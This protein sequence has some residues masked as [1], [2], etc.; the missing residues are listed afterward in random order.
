MNVNMDTKSIRKNI[1]KSQHCQRNWLL[2]RSIPGSDLETLKIAVTECP[3]KQN[4]A[5]Y[6]VHFVL[7]RPLIEKIHSA[8]DGFVYSFSPKKVTTNSQILA[9]LVV[10]FEKLPISIVAKQDQW[11]NEETLKTRS[12][13]D[14][15]AITLESDQ[16]IAIGIAAGYLN[17]TANLLG[18]STG[19]CSCFAENLVTEAL[20]LEYSPALLM[21]IGYPNESVGR[22]LHHLDNKFMF[23]TL[24]KQA[25]SLK[26]YK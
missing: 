5:F 8:T 14:P 16:K 2:T 9:N 23:P 10:V 25:I 7:N 21:G 22:R 24:K 15:H 6:K 17:L 26:T 19:C 1:K 4:I 20:N 18:L 13:D 3:S 11:R 12:S